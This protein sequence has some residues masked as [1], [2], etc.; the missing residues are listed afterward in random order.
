MRQ[1]LEARLAV[2]DAERAAAERGKLDKEEFAHRAL[3]K[4]TV[5]KDK[6]VQESKKLQQ[7]A[8]DNA[9]VTTII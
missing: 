8:E 4:Q 7:A 2:A 3:A 9:K 6:A 1:N 5:I